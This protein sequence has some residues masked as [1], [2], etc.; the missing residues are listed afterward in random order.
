MLERKMGVIAVATFAPR[1]L[2][3]ETLLSLALIR[4]IAPEER[5]QRGVT[6]DPV[7]ESVDQGADR[8][9]GADAGDEIAAE[10]ATCACG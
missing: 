8:R 9:G 1:P 7:V 5:P 2:G 6:F 3:E 4:E 10:E